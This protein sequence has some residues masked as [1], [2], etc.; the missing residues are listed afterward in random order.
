[1]RPWVKSYKK[2]IQEQKKMGAS[3]VEPK[4]GKARGRPLILD[5]ALNLKLRSMLVKL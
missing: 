3:S 2:S 5:E 1:M 4:I